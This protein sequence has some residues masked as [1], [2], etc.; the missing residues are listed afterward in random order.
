M[1]SFLAF[2]KKEITEQIRSGKLTILAMLF[3]LFGIMNPAVAKLTPWLLEVMA[4][5]MAESGMTVTV[6]SITAMDSWVQFFKNIPMQLPLPTPFRKS[7]N[8]RSAG[9]DITGQ[10]LLISSEH[11]QKSVLIFMGKCPIIWNHLPRCLVWAEKR[12]MWF[13][14]IFFRFPV[15]RWILM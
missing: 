11:V 8:S 12:Q 4:D 2:M 10:K 9:A 1:K 5:S 6:V 15:F 13:W 3:I 14:G 7:W